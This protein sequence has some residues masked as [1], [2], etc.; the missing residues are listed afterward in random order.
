[1][2]SSTSSCLTTTKAHKIVSS[3]FSSSSFS[4][5][6]ELA[7]AAALEQELG[8]R[9][10]KST[11][12]HEYYMNLRTPP[13]TPFVSFAVL[14]SPSNL[15]ASE[16]TR[17]S[18]LLSWLPPMAE[19]ENYIMTYRSSDG[20]RKVSSLSPPPPKNRALHVGFVERTAQDS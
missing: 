4:T 11:Q 12:Q 1:M 16:V 2:P 5:L 13:L 9:F 14:D 7:S 19:I 18:V 6:I 8:H 3:R 20:S 10:R 17:R 15:T